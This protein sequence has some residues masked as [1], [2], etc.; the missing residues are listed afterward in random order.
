MKRKTSS[1]AKIRAALAKGL[2]VSEVVS[3]LGVQ[4]TL[5]YV[6]KSAMNRKNLISFGTLAEPTEERTAAVDM[7]NHPPHYKVGGIE[8]IEYIRAKLTPTEYVGYLKGSVIK[9]SSRIGHKGE[10]LQDAGKLSWY[11][12]ELTKALA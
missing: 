12:T 7:V 10:A 2:S 9:Y 4:R 11:A 8:T 6:V 3:K 5:V 1:S